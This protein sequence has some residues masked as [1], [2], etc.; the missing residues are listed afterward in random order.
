MQL[1][2]GLDSIV[3]KDAPVGKYTWYGLGG[4]AEYLIRPDNHEQLAEVAQ[5]CTENSIPIHVLG[6]GSNVLI[7]DAGVKGAVIKLDSAAFS[8]VS[9]KGD[10]VLAGSG[11]SLNEVVLNCVREGLSGLECVTGIPG[12]VGGAVRMNAGGK[13][14]DIGTSIVSLK[15]MD[16]LGSI[17]VKSKPDIEFDYRSSNITEPFI[18]E[19]EFKL[20]KSDPDRVMKATQEIW[21]YKKNIQPVTG[22]TAGCVFKNPSVDTAGSLIDRAGLKGLKA[23][24]AQ[25]SE[26]HGNFIIADKDTKSSDIIELIE[27]IQQKVQQEFDVELELEIEIW[28]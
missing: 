13:F 11:A 1:F 17:Y 2:N 20:F 24:T 12:S 28:T 3:K 19:A 27:I 15:L 10:R 18:L 16:D 4:N 6:L 9:Y 23:G 5:I 22:R 8:D 7:S 26:K 14:G 21:I 25:V